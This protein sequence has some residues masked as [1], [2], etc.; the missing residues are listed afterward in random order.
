[1][2]TVDGESESSALALPT[3][4]TSWITSAF[5]WPVR[6]HPNA[7]DLIRQFQRDNQIRHAAWQAKTS[8]VSNTSIQDLMIVFIDRGSEAPSPCPKL[9]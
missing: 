1:M 3:F 5:S 9:F 8:L 4:N 7:R 6:A 2:T